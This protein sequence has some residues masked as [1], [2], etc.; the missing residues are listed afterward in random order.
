[1]G[2]GAGETPEGRALRIDAVIERMAKVRLMA[3]R[4]RVQQLACLLAERERIGG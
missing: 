4:L 3:E 1:M 2:S